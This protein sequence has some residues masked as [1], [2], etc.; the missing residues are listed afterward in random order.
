MQDQITSYKIHIL[1]KILSLY[2][3]DYSKM[4]YRPEKKQYNELKMKQWQLDIFYE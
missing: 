2:Y 4:L 1:S 3:N